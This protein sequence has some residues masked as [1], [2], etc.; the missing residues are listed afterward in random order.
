MKVHERGKGE[1]N[2]LVLVTCVNPAG[3]NFDCA[4]CDEAGV[5]Q[6]CS[7]DDGSH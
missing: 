2:N 1:K 4:I 5:K 6:C 3:D 7:A